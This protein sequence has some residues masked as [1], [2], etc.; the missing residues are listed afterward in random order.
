VFKGT[1]RYRT[2]AK[3]RVPVPAPFRRALGEEPRLVVTVL[4]QCLAAY[5]PAEW[6]RLETQLSA[7]PSF[8][9]PVKAVTRL[10]ASRAADC[11]LDVQGRI[12]LPPPL[13]QAAG[14]GREVVVVGVLNRIELWSP[15]AWESFVKESEGLLDDVSLDLQWPPPPGAPAAP[16]STAPE[17]P[18]RPRKPRR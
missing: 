3:G 2:D 9:K 4:D 14:L 10:L 13:R 17:T 11:A 5:A 15:P 7:L 8:S 1:Y 6:A 18:L 12:L 16:P